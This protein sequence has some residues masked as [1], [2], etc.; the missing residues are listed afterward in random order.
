MY[1]DELKSV[2]GLLKAVILVF[3][4]GLHKETKPE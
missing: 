1:D 2:G 4:M 3:T